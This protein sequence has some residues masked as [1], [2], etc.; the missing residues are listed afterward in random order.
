MTNTHELSGHEQP[1]IY[2]SGNAW[3]YGYWLV[4]EMQAY[5][6]TSFH[7]EHCCRRLLDTYKVP[8]LRK[9]RTRIHLFFVLVECR[10]SDRGRARGSTGTSMAISVFP[11]ELDGP[12][13]QRL[14][15]PTVRCAP[16][17]GPTD[18]YTTKFV[19]LSRTTAVELS[20]ATQETTTAI[21]TAN[22]MLASAIIT[23][24]MNGSP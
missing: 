19:V 4:Y 6:D 9:S 22:T 5:N 10:R 17:A 15:A 1:S 23:T 24:A 20:I 21:A 8:P 14:R 7:D 13:R 2:K 18:V 16:M 12:Q 3:Q 11:Q